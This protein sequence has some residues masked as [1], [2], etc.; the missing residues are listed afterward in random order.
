VTYLW[1]CTQCSFTGESFR[2]DEGP[3]HKHALRRDYKAEN[4]NVWT[5]T[6]ALGDGKVGVKVVGEGGGAEEHMPRTAS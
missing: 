2:S 4:S 5:F 6:N 1:K 3:A